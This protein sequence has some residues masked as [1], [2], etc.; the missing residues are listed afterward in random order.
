L[1]LDKHLGSWLNVR[2]TE[3]FAAAKHSV[4]SLCAALVLVQPG[5]SCK[6]VF[7]VL[8]LLLGFGGC[9]CRLLL[10]GLGGVALLL[11]LRR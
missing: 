1:G 5:L 6:L 10:A 11:G 7:L 8:V 2:A 4:I 9:A 3:H